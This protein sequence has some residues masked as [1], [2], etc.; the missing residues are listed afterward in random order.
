MSLILDE[1]HCQLS[2]TAREFL[3]ANAP[4]AALR[5]LRDTRDER[6]WSRDLWQRMAALGWAGITIPEQ[7]GG[8]DFGFAGLGVLLEETGRTLCASPLF[9]TCVLGSSAL[10]L[11][12]SAAQKS[13]FLPR[14]AAG[15]LT[16]ALALEES[17]RH[18]PLATALAAVRDTDG[19]C[20]SGSKQ[21]VL[22]GHSAELLIVLART[23]GHAGDAAGLSLFAVDG[24]AP[25]LLRR[26]LSLMDSR[27]A[28]RID[29]EDVRI[30]ADALLGVEGEA[31]AVLDQLLD[32]G[33]AGI[34]A[35]ML[36]GMQEC[37]ARTVDYLK[38]REQFG[39]LIG[40]FQALQHRAAHAHTEIELTR[41]AVRAACA[42]VDARDGLLPFA[43]SLAKARANDTWELISNE[44]VQMHGGIG[45]TDALDIGLFLKR[46]RVAMQIL[47]DAAFHRDR[48]ARLRDF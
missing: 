29:F 48:Y 10:V 37:C 33:R 41:S 32:R 11:A 43:A 44:A 13:A 1:A 28:A 16:L 45:T 31:H 42:A 26:R 38:Q 30:R 22:D 8:L 25:G 36:G 20:L 18:D 23:A 14:I 19:Y 2:D 40:S 27:N 24:A 3:A 35:E 7:Y 15:E 6:G 4:V 12:G 39:A 5:R 17:H 21:F 47:G 34:A 9:A 46:S